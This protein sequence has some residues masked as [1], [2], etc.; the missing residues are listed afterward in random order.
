MSDVFFPGCRMKSGYPAMSEKLAVYMNEHCGLTPTGCCKERYSELGEGDRAI[1]ICN[2]C[3]VELRSLGKKNVSN[4]YVPEILDVDE[5]F[6]FPDLEGREF[7]LQECDHGYGRERHMEQHVYS[8]MTKMNARIR[9]RTM[10]RVPDGLQYPEH[11]AIVKRNLAGMPEGPVVTYCPICNL[12]M[13]QAG[14]ETYMLAE[15][16]FSEK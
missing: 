3:A 5:E 16:V 13:K 9:P 1:L 4:L 12:I 7:I 2:N 8:L 6:A 14:R 10:E 11:A 15:L